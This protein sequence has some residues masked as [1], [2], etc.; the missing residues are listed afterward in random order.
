ML[1]MKTLPKKDERNWSK[2]GIIVLGVGFAL[3]FVGSYVLSILTGS[4]FVPAVK[5][6]DS[7]TIDLTIRDYLGR[8]VLTTDQQLYSGTINNG[9]LVFFMQKMTIPAN[10]TFNQ[11]FVGINAY[12]PSSAGGWVTFGMLGPELQLISSELIG[13]HAGE[14]K[15]IDLSSLYTSSSVLSRENFEQL[16]GNYTQAG[17]GQMYP[18]EF[19]DQPSVDLD[20]SN[21]SARYYRV[22]E[23]IDKA[24]ENITLSYLYSSAEISIVSTNRG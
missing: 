3:L 12:L 10:S 13:M 15:T 17:V 6:G 14:T 9:N 24:E 4:V 21:P 22:V 1:A 8:P 5:A 7:V 18:W 2:I 20:P 19:A 16:G 23:I 11:T